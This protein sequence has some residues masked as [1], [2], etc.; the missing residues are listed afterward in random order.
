MARQETAKKNTSTKLKT[1][2]K[3]KML[4]SARWA[5]EIIVG[6][7]T[8]NRRMYRKKATK[9]VTVSSIV[10][11]VSFALVLDASTIL[12]SPVDV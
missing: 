2:A 11:R 7:S 4:I 3:E 8:L 5:V 6:M 1:I 12:R 9:P 10:L